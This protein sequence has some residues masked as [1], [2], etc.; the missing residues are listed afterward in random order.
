MAS[1]TVI[2]VFDKSDYSKHR[3][4]T[5]PATPPSAL[6]PSS[7]RLKTKI[8]GQTTNNLTYALLGF[9]L[10]WWDIYPQPENTPAPYNDRSKYACIA[11]WGYAEIVQSTVPDIPAGASVFGYLHI[12]TGTWDVRVKHTNLKN[13]IVVLDEHRQHLWKIYN[14]L[15]VHPPLSELEHTKGADSLG[16]DSLMYVLFGTGHNLSTFG[17]AWK[18]SVRIHPAGEGNWTA[19]D[20]N[21]GDAT[22]IVLNAGGKTGMSFAYALRQDRPKEHQPRTIIGVGSEASKP[23]LE[24]SG[25]YDEVLLN[26]DGEAAKSLAEASSPRRVLLFDFGSRPGTMAAFTASLSSASAPLSRFFVG[27]D[28]RPKKA[29]D[30]MK[31]RGQ[32][33]EG[34]QVNA[35]T[36]REKGIEVGGDKYFE[37]FGEA[38][39]GFKNKGAI[40]GTTLVWGEGLEGWEKGWEAFCKDEVRGTEGRVYR[41]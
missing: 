23:L 25:F 20:A 28:N 27:G 3:L 40:P 16:W 14:R 5:I 26:T 24:K 29:E 30:V 1:N 32:M 2:H 17:F 4:V 15:Q 36:L 41:L 21:V 31:A 10:G 9:A 12:G 22:V 11:G 37:E 35:N 38:W 18:D 34:V 33:G 6:A 19:E 7:L 39:E 13:Q 8:L